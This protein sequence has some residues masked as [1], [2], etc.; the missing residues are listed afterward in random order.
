MYAR[1]IGHVACGIE[2]RSRIKQHPLHFYLPPPPS[3][4]IVVYIEDRNVVP[5]IIIRNGGFVSYLYEKEMMNMSTVP[6]QI[7]MDAD[8]KKTSHSC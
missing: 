5:P 7:R 1:C 6:I 4:Q 2:S 8:V 3:K